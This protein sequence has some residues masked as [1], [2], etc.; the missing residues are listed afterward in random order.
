[1]KKFFAYILVIIILTSVFI[2]SYSYSNIYKSS[3]SSE[4]EVFVIEQGQSVK[5]IGN[6]L[7]D[8]NFIRSQLIFESYVWLRRAQAKFQ[9]GE[10]ELNKGLSMKELIDTFVSGQSLSKERDIKLIEGWNAREI[11][12]SL[13]AQGAINS[14]KDFL[15][16]IKY[17][18]S[19]TNGYNFLKDKPSKRSLEGYLFP[20]TYTIYKDATTE[21][22]LKKMLDNFDAKLT[23]QMRVDIE[24]SGLPIFEIITMASIIE[25]EVPK[26]A[27][28]RMISDI[29]WKRVEAGM[30][31]QSDATINYITGKNDPS[32]SLDDL[33]VDSLYNTYLYPDL[34]PGPIGNPGVSAIQAAIYRAPNDYWFYLS[35]P[36][37][38]TV[39][40]K[41]HDEHVRNKQ[42][43]LK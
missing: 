26:S 41:D 27:D 16:K 14:A 23:P 28:R 17:Y 32:P 30:P 18:G 9:A 25:L 33:K 38:E 22:I 2:L 7:K 11:A 31:L 40:S 6:N 15:D 20:D 4:S 24:K 34:P 3:L 12:E 1:M 39:F 35:K 29:F 5:Q 19:A 42:K 13:E 8:T 36:T 10:Y 21:D 43:Y 37:G